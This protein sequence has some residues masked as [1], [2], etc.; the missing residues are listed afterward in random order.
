MA[1][2]TMADRCYCVPCV[3]CALCCTSMHNRGLAAGQ[4]VV[5]VRYGSPEAV[6]YIVQS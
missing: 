3:S 2:T 5:T 1:S 6:L 4:L